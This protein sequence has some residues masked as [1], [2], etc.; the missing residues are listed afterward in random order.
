M[1]RPN[2][3]RPKKG[4]TDEEQSEEHA[5]SIFLTSRRLF[6]RNS[7]WQAKQSVLH[8][9]VMFYNNCVKMCEDFAQNFGD[10]RTGCCITTT[11]FLTLPVSP[12]NF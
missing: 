6:T 5:F 11:H 3:L 2:S 1:K 8:I 10:K 7:A 9:T 12:G 4:E